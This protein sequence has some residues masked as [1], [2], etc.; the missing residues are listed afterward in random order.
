MHS[1]YSIFPK[2]PWLSIYAWVVFCILPFFFILRTASPIDLTIGFTL[3]VF[4]FLSYY[5][6]VKS[7]SGLMYMWISFEIVITVVMTLLFGYVYLSIFI[8]FFIGNIRNPIGFFIIYGL[9]IAILIGAVV[10]GF[11]IEIDLFLPQIHFII[12]SII[13]VVLLPF[14]LYNRQK[15][16]RLQDQLIVA[17]ERISE[18]TIVQERERIAR[19]LHDT[20]GQKLSMI[21]LKSD[22]AMRLMERDAQAA[23]AEIQD[24]RQI[25]STALKEVRVLV[26]GMRRIKLR[27]ELVRVQQLLKAAEIEVKLEGDPNFPDMS[28]IVENVLV[29]CL[30]E[31]INNVVKHSYAKQC[32]IAFEQ[33]TK[34]FIIKVKDNGIGIAQNGVN[35]PGNGLDGM[36]ERLE[37][38]NG[39][40]S[41]TSLEGTQ[42]TITVPAVLKQIKEG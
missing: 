28:P 9:H 23:V 7:Q 8:A 3:L 16:D 13:G 40:L 4:F 32:C 30:K 38:V 29:M 11:F 25:S 19:D 35:L 41:I 33:S 34:E 20:L 26:S 37:F 10:A 36:Q 17:Q 1:W 12:V 21:G 15:R 2:S 24:I 31:A 42:V 6:S 14:N 5:F 22:L 39:S 27:D 18:L